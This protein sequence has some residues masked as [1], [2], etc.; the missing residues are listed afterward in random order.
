MLFPRVIYFHQFV[1]T[2]RPDHAFFR[3][4]STPEAFRDFVRQ[5]KR[6]YHVIGV[7]EFYRAW[8]DGQ[9]W[10]PNSVLFT[11]DDGFRNNLY[12]ARVLHD[13]GLSGVFFV[14]SD[15]IDSDFT[16][17]YLRL[18]HLQSSRH[19]SVCTFDGRSYNLDVPMQRRRWRHRF[20]ERMLSVPLVEQDALLARLADELDAAPIDPFDEDYAFFRGEDLRKL[21]AMGMSV[22]SHGAT[23]PD[24]SRIT[25]RELE[26]EIVESREKLA[27]WLGQPV[28]TISYPY[29]CFDDRALELVSRHYRFGFT[30]S[31]RFSADNPWRYP[32]RLARTDMRVLSS[33]YPLKVSC[34]S[35]AKKC[36]GCG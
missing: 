34:L 36:L 6:R 30:A 7:E 35:L 28:T 9:R 10:P 14:L 11:F 26:Y 32:R 25:D 18:A 16:P 33:W 22:G 23:H 29:G 12:A 2:P 8:R 4:S 13:E 5:V 3:Y 31:P 17:S 21:V 24:F 27:H 15:V 19:R 1:V 20:N